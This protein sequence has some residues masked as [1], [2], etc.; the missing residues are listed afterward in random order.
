MPQAPVTFLALTTTGPSPDEDRVVEAAAVR[1]GADGTEQ[2][3]VAVA[4]PGK[5]SPAALQFAGLDAAAVAGKPSPRSVL[6]RTFK[7]CGA[8][9]VVV[10]DADAFGAF[11]EAAGVPP[12]A[13]VDARRLAQIARPQA[14]DYTLAGVAADLGLDPPAGRR[15][16]DRARLIARVWRVLLEELGKLPPAVRHLVCRLAEAAIDPLAP[17]LADVAHGGDFELSSEPE[18]D[19]RGLFPEHSDLLRRVQRN[20]EAEPADDAIPTDGICRMFQGNGPVGRLLEGYEQRPQ[21]VDMVRAVCEALNEPHHLMVEAG[22]GTG[23]SMAYLLP[24]VAWAC[25]NRDKV[26]ISTNTRNL[27]EQLYRKDLPFLGTLLPGRFEPALLKGRRNYLCVRR[28][29][30]LVRHFERELADAEEIMALAPLAAWAARTESGDLAECNGFNFSPAAL[31]VAQAVTSGRDE[32]AGPGCRFR[33]RCKVNRARA[34]AQLADLIV[35]NHALIFA[36]LGLDSPVLPP[37]RCLIFDEAHN[38]EDVATEALATVVDAPGIFRITRFLYRTQRDGSGSG[39]L[40]TVM[41]EV[42]RSLRRGAQEPVREGCGQA[43]AAVQEVVDAARQFF[44]TLAAP[45]YELP[46]HVDRIMLQECHPQIGPGSET[47]D[48]AQALRETIAALGKN[49]QL[50]GASDGS[51]DM[52]ELADDLRAQSARLREFADAVEFVLSQ[53]ADN[54]V[55][56]VE[57]TTRERATFYSVHA[58]PL[59]VGSYIRDFFLQEKRCVIFTSATLQVDG[60]FDYMLERLGADEPGPQ[61]VRCLAVGSPFDYERQTMFGVT[62][63]LRR[64]GARWCFSLPIPCWKAS[65]PRSRTR[66]K[67]PA[68]WCWRRATAA[69]A[70]PSRRCSAATSPACCSAPG[71]SGKGWISRGRRSVAWC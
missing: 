23:K 22:T 51:E 58:A 21:Q 18:A 56:W 71:A 44:D 69:A 36:E 40:S 26:V 28:F 4:N 17:V 50:E 34:L 49:A 8:G 39:L 43:M 27:Q 38:L 24:A 70:R 57:R 61:P 53:E 12:P 1:V 55:Y 29:M 3:L 13:C 10:Y 64:T 52:T 20:E 15:A 68:S 59:Q 60:T 37:H 33:S 46:P 63:F 67:E 62:T 25:T 41:Y 7:F 45:F 14:S 42:E 35:V 32:C 2:E 47:W 5:L 31:S 11:V 65:T 6:R 54:F 9:L 48:A 19:L 16:L 30:H 66:W